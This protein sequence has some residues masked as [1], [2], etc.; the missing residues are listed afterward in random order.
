VAHTI[1]LQDSSFGALIEEIAD[2]PDIHPEAIGGHR[3]APGTVIGGAF[4]VMTLLGEGGMSEVYLARDVSL[5][6]E[7]ALKL[8]RVRASEAGRQRLAEKEAHATATLNHPN[9]VTL[10]QFGSWEG[11]YYLVL[12]RLHGETLADRLSRG[13][14]EAREALAIMVEVLRGIAHAHKL[15]ILHRDLKP[16]N[17]FLCADGRV[18][19]LDFGL[20]GM[21][22]ATSAAAGARAAPGQTFAFAGTPAYMAPEQ[23]R[24][25]PQDAR[26]DVWALG[27]LLFELVTGGLP[28]QARGADDLREVPLARAPAVLGDALA[29]ALAFAPERRLADAG[30]LLQRLDRARAGRWRWRLLA[31]AVAVAGIAGA[32]TVGERAPAAERDAPIDLRQIDLSGEWH[33]LT[34]QQKFELTR[35]APMQYRYRFTDAGEWGAPSPEHIMVEGILTVPEG[36]TPEVVLG[37]NV[38]DV[39]GSKNDHVGYMAFTVHAPDYMM[40]TDSLWGPTRDSLK[41]RY[42]PWP[43]VRF[44]GP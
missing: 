18:K 31:A 26:V 3:L 22:R 15:G 8:I 23:W 33:W 25:E 29:G 1:P 28:F 42:K 6:R 21:M 20:A 24:G 27:V 40:M 41:F 14:L 36:D 37:G 10:Y 19:V 35:L 5:D 11:G 32:V 38:E 34:G 30:E 12:E 7:V 43:V 44:K 17:V 9:I 4:E 13:R 16:H 2:A 39:H